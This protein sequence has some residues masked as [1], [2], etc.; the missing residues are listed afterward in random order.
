MQVGVHLS[1]F[2]YCSPRRLPIYF[3]GV[4]EQ[5]CYPRS[6]DVHVLQ[7]VYFDE[8]FTLNLLVYPP[9]VE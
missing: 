3:Y 1:T 4:L 6:T 8:H 9:P 5:S 7:Y 2:C